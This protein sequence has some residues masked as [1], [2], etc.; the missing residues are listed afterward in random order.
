MSYALIDSVLSSWAEKHGVSWSTQYQDTEVRSVT[1]VSSEGKKFQIWVDPPGH[2]DIK[3]HAW[4]Y[5]RRRED[6]GANTRTLA[7]VLDKALATV[8]DWMN[9]SS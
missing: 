7:A 4:D 8:K 6:F 9:V 3:V 5:K 1:V 2:T